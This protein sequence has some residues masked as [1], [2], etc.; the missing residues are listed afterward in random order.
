M[1]IMKGLDMPGLGLTQ[2]IEGI[3]INWLFGSSELFNE[4]LT[5]KSAL[6]EGVPWLNS[7][8]FN[9]L[10]GFPF[11]LSLLL[12]IGAVS[13]LFLLVYGACSLVKLLK[14]DKGEKGA[15]SS[16]IDESESPRR[17]RRRRRR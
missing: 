13:F 12:Q 8:W 17:R 16:P 2:A 14:V 11:V 6:L 5:E 7:I 1:E 15:L 9:L 4:W 10:A 3:L